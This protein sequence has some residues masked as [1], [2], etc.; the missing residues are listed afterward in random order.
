MAAHECHLTHTRIHT[1]FSTLVPVCCNL[2]VNEEHDAH[3]GDAHAGDDDADDDDVLM[4]VMMMIVMTPV[5]HDN[6]DTV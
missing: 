1:A 3:A 6:I 4:I 5:T 2:Q